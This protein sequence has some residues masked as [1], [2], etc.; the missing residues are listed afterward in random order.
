MAL[1][2]GRSRLPELLAQ[3]NR[4]QAD[5]AKHLGVTESYISQVIKGKSKLSVL[6]MKMAADY[7]NCNMDDLFEWEWE[8]GKR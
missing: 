5:L 2:F 8:T 6:K 1:R 4:T 7:L 3:T